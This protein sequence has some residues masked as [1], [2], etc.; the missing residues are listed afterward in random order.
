[1][2]MLAIKNQGSACIARCAIITAKVRWIFK[3]DTNSHTCLLKEKRRPAC[4]ANVV[5]VVTIATATTGGVITITVAI[6][7]AI[8]AVVMSAAIITFRRRLATNIQCCR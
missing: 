5:T 4:L 7:F 6:V 2:V 8:S 3:A 1:M